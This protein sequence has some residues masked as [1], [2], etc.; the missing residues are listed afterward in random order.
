MLLFYLQVIP[1]PIDLLQ[2]Q[3]N[4]KAEKYQNEEQFVNDLKLMFENCRK[5]NEENSV[6][7]K[8]ANNLEKV[9]ND[10]LKELGPLHEGSTPKKPGMKTY[11]PRRKLNPTDAK[12]KQ[13]YETI[14]ECRDAKGRQLSLVF[15]KLPSKT[16]YPDYYEVI[17]KPM[18]MDKIGSK[19]KLGQYENL[20]DLVADLILMLDNACKFNEPDSQIY[21]VK[22][23]LIFFFMI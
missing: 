2:I 17:K 23:N 21:K 1:E 19:L 3:S 9:L 22:L 13:L 6:I 20:D 11:K 5:F 8:D 12:L 7:Y 16:D 4:I 18:D 15:T 14:K 10:K